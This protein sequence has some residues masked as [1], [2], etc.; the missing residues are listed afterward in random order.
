VGDYSAEIIDRPVI[1]DCKPKDDLKIKKILC[2]NGFTI[3]VQVPKENYCAENEHRYSKLINKLD[4]RQTQSI[5]NK[6][7]I[8][9]KRN[10]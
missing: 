6:N 10:M 9:N 1:L 8:Q 3:F 4:D 5:D 2:G 7:V